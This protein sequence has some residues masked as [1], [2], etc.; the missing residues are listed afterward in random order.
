MQP[1]HRHSA[2]QRQSQCRRARCAKGE[3]VTDEHLVVFTPP[4][5]VRGQSISMI[6]RCLTSAIS[7]SNKASYSPHKLLVEN[8][9]AL[10]EDD[11]GRRALLQVD[12]PAPLI[13][14]CHAFKILTSG[15]LNFF[16]N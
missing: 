11:A 7:N 8:I 16:S 4:Q 3:A 10:A 13:D 9:V 12:P 15:H 5:E 6:F 2:C 14:P 1:M